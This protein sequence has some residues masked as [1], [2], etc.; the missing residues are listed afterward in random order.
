MT[1]LPRR[2]LTIS[3]AALALSVAACA[4]PLD[5]PADYDYR[6]KHALVVEPTVAVMQ[7]TAADGVLAAED[8]GRL[9][10][11]ASDFMRRGDAVVEI[12]VGAGHADEV[13]PRILGQAIAATLAQAGLKVAEM[14]LQLVLDEP[15]IAPGG[16][17]LSFKTTTVRLPDCY[18]WSDGPRNAPSAN[19]GCS[20]QRNFGAMV[21]NPRDLL[22]E[23]ASD[24]ASGARMGDVV[25]K[26]GQ[27][28]GTW[29]APLPI[30]A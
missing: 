5:H 28:T 21:A 20:M 13:A 10:E 24:G 29:T 2:L 14:R 7:L 8:R 30:T 3:A 27:G 1:H 12:S 19:F 16:A 15:A 25:D 11:F 18:D 26:Y 17:F 23:R 22:Q 4:S 9:I 6:E